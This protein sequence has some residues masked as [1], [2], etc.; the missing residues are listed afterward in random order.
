MRRVTGSTIAEFGPAF[1]ILI[2]GVLVPLL[3]LI[4]LAAQYSTAQAV[5]SEFT[6]KLAHAESRSHAY[7]MLANDTAARDFLAKMGVQVKE[8]ELLIVATSPGSTEELNVKQGDPVPADWLPGSGKEGKAY[9][10][11]LKTTLKIPIALFNHPIDIDYRGRA[12]WA[13]LGSNPETE[14]YYINE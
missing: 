5:L 8:P 6:E 4:W 3:Y 14:E 12:V 13:N 11:E 2:I 10:L 1:F 7:K 9:F